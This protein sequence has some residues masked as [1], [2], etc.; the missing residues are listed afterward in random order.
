V[1]G[2][3]ALAPGAPVIEARGVTKVFAEGPQLVPALRGID[4]T[5]RAGEFL[6]LVGPSGAARPRS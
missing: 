2:R 6:A 4:L 3:A 1:S 5:V